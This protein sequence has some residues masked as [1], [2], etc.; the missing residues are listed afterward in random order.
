MFAWGTHIWGRKPA[1][2]VE[3]VI[4]AIN[5][6]DFATLATSVIS[7]VRFIDSMGDGVAGQQAAFLLLQ[8]MIACDPDLRIHVDE[9]TGHDDA[10]LVTGRISGSQKMSSQRTL[11]KIVLQDGLVAEWRS[12]SADNPLPVTRI[13]MGS[14]ARA[15]A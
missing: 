15:F 10:V 9:M 2:L 14:E 1:R 7:D 11:W 8:R 5:A 3:R 12:F 13:L 6:R 4:A